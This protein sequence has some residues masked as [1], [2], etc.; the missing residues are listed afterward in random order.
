MFI[1]NLRIYRFNSYITQIIFI[2][3]IDIF[4]INTLKKNIE[5]F[6]GNIIDISYFFLLIFMIY[7]I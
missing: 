7:M 6:S 3:D 2:I 1:S 4:I 5:N